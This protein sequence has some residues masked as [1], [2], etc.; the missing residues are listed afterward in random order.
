MAEVVLAALR[1]NFPGQFKSY[2]PSEDMIRQ[3]T[4]AYAVKLSGLTKQQVLSGIDK[5][6]NREFMPNPHEFA[7]C[8]LT[9]PSEVGVPAP[10]D[11]V[12]AVLRWRQCKS[13]SIHPAAYSAYLR[14]DVYAWDRM[15]TK[16]HAEY[17]KYHYQHVVDEFMQ[18]IPLKSPPP[19]IEKKPQKKCPSSKEKAHNEL[20]KLLDLL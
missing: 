2:Y 13:L 7:K 5:A 10:Q 3:A 8:C 15:D 9:T 4:K 18:G 6:T 20:K 19:A 1:L 16:Q 11:A 14:L 17:F 12:R